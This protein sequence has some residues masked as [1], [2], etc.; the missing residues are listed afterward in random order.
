MSLVPTS[1]Y[2]LGEKDLKQSFFGSYV[3]MSVFEPFPPWLR[4]ITYR[5]LAEVPRTLPASYVT[6]S[7]F[8]LA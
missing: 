6:S 5:H 4:S 1:G 2:S 8:A 3:K 7:K